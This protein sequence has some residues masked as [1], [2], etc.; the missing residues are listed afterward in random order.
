MNQNRYKNQKG[1]GFIQNI[2]F[3]ALI[4]LAA[5]VVYK[6]FHNPENQNP[7]RASQDLLTK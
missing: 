6:Y 2:L 3:L 1:G 4:A 7:T 5:F